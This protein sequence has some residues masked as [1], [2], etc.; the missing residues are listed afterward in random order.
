[1]NVELR[2]WTLNDRQA[3]KR[4][5]NNVD[6]TFL[7]DRMPYPYSDEDAEWWLN[8]VGKSDGIDGTFR[9]IV[10]NGDVVGSISVER[11]AD[12]YRLDGEL[13]YM[14]LTEFWNKGIISEA[15]PQVCK[16]SFSTLQLNRITANVFQPNTA[17]HRVLLKNSFLL[18]GIKRDAVIKDGN[19]YD[20]SIYGLLK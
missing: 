9:A 8:M 20:V 15:I 5:C 16:L 19:V 18:E 4:L 10:V 3:L 1:M 12:V 14:L 2:K 13:G 17:S 7:S 6:R 11:Q